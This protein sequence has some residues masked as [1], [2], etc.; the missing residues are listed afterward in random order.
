MVEQRKWQR[1]LLIREDAAIK[2]FGRAVPLTPALSPSEGERENRRPIAELREKVRR[3]SVGLGR[4]NP[5]AK[6]RV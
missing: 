5:E 1:V 4:D 3:E 2:Q 6:D